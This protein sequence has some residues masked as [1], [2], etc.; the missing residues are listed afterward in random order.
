[1]GYSPYQ[2]TYKYKTPFYKVK[3]KTPYPI[4]DAGGQFGGGGFGGPYGG[5]FGGGFGYPGFHQ[6]FGFGWG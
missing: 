4:G 2:Y 1:M 5:G 3:I 6:P